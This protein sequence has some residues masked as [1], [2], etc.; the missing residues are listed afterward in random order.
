M[1]Q[2]VRVL[3]YVNQFFGGIGGEDKAMYAPQAKE[4]PVGPGT[5]VQNAFKSKGINAQIVA[6][7]ICGDDYAGKDTTRAAEEVLQLMIPYHPDVVLAGPAFNAGRYG[8][9]CGTVCKL[10]RE[11]LGIPAVTA[12]YQ[13]NPGADMYRKHLYIVRTTDSA[14][15][16]ADAIDKMVNLAIKLV[17]KQEIGLPEEE[18]YI[19]RGLQRRVLVDRPAAVRSVD[20]LLARLKGEPFETEL[21]LPKFVRAKPP[22]AMK[23]LSSARLGLVTDGGLVPKGNPD[24]IEKLIATRYGRYRIEGLN[25]FNPADWS[26]SH[27]GYDNTPILQ[28]P[29]RLIPLDV[30]RD[31]E[32]EHVIGKVDEYF[33]STC[34]CAGTI[35]NC[36]KMGQSIAAQLKEDKVNAVL[37]TAT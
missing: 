7:A 27:A 25:S 11:K 26:V 17:N 28:D 19:R 6:T 12:M 20:M 15:G 23:D 4:G 3:H 10:V 1:N 33:Y 31:M 5:A 16:M 36:S 2:T 29:D 9:A 35:E 37:L 32:K 34:G 24:K 21:H 13:E 14:R 18:N 30:L 8:V 22:A